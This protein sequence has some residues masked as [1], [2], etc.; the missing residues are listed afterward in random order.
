MKNSSGLA[1]DTTEAFGRDVYYYHPSEY[2]EEI[3][4]PVDG[5]VEVTG[6][7]AT[8][9]GYSD[10]SHQLSVNGTP[11]TRSHGGYFKCD[12]KLTSG[13]NSFEFVCGD[14]KKEITIIKK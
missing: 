12:L 11:V 7:S 3:V 10:P 1:D 4:L 6:N 9:H 13:E 2:T 14:A 8:F 5:G